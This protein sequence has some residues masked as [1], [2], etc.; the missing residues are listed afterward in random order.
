MNQKHRLKNG[1]EILVRRLCTEILEAS[2]KVTEL[3]NDEWVVLYN[4]Y[5]FVKR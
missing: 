1:T 2:T 3:V 5:G 4:K